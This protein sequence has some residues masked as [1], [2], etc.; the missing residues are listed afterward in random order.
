MP[1][2]SAPVIPKGFLEIRIFLPVFDYV[3]QPI[4]FPALIDPDFHEMIQQNQPGI[5][6]CLLQIRVL[7]RI[8]TFIENIF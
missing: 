1:E 6:K 2:I 7:I 8:V 3:Y 5:A 4:H